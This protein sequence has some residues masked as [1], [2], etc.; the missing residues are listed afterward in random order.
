MDNNG[1]N[2]TYGIWAGPVR[3]DKRRTRFFFLNGREYYYIY[4][5]PV[6]NI[7][8]VFIYL[9]SYDPWLIPIRG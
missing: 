1:L 4:L 9:F 2:S 7:A 3:V 6:A 5:R 8:V